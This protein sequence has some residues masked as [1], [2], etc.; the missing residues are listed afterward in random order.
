MKL[1]KR[2]FAPLS[3]WEITSD[4]AAV[5]MQL[6]RV[7]SSSIR[8]GERETGMAGFIIRGGKFALPVRCASRTNHAGKVVCCHLVGFS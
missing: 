7:A 1:A 6:S 4:L 8:D 3:L 2:D 5:V